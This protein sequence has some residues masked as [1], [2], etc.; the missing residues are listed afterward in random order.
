MSPAVG[1]IVLSTTAAPRYELQ[2][3]SKP[4]VELPG[5][6][7]RASA[8][9]VDSDTG[10]TLA[11]VPERVYVRYSWYNN[12]AKRYGFGGDFRDPTFS[13]PTMF[14]NFLSVSQ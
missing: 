5:T 11:T 3:N 7:I 4:D 10:A 2:I 13:L 12:Q 1:N 6:L 8:S 14:R 9:L